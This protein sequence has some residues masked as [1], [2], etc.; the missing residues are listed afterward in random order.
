[1]Q[2][3]TW[4]FDI[5]SPYAYLHFKLHDKITV[6]LDIEY[7]PVLFAG[8]LKAHGMKGPAEITEKRRHTYRM[9]VWFAREHGIEFRL[10]PAHPFTPLHALRLLIGAGV[11]RPNIEAV[12]DCIWKDGQDVNHPTVFAALAAKLGVGDPAEMIARPEVKQQLLTN[13]ERALQRGIYGVPTFEIGDE[14]FWGADT[15]PMMNAWLKEQNLFNEF[16]MAKIDLLPHA[17]IRKEAASVVSQRFQRRT[18]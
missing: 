18:P 7:A 5:I 12:F 4:Y 10:P 6:P 8:L 3:A 11:N 15:L 13:T 17:S 16:E 9:C 2:R 1:M 14:L